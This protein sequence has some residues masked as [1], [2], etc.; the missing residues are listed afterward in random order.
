MVAAMSFSSVRVRRSCQSSE[1]CVYLSRNSLGIVKRFL[2]GVGSLIAFLKRRAALHVQSRLI[3]RVTTMNNSRR[4]K[5][6]FEWNVPS[7]ANI[8]SSAKAEILEIQRQQGIKEPAKD[9]FKFTEPRVSDS[10]DSK[11][12]FSCLSLDDD[13]NFCMQN[14]TEERKIMTQSIILILFVV[15]VNF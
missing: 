6:P 7:S 15:F 13:V 8:S 9:E 5:E 14:H 4:A 1:F 11:I 3:C 10:R 2:I 12:A